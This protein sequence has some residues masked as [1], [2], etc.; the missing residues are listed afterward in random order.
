MHSWGDEWEGWD[1]LYKAEK[2]M[3]TFYKKCTG[4]YMMSKEKWGTIRY[5]FTSMWIE[6]EMD[7]FIFREMIRRAIKKFPTI[8]R[9]IVS[10]AGHTLNDE[11]FDGWC[12]GVSAVTGDSY[13]SSKKRPNGV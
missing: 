9:E 13:W 7:C 2:W 5:E 11:Y 6:S 4:K 10:D 3:R 12:N 1:T 8:A